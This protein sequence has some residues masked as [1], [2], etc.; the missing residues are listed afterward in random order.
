MIQIFGVASEDRIFGEGSNNQF[1]G[2]RRRAVFTIGISKKRL[3]APIKRVGFMG[4]DNDQPMQIEIQPSAEYK[5]GL[6]DLGFELHVSIMGERFHRLKGSFFVETTNNIYYWLKNKGEMDFEFDG[7][8]RLVLTD[9]GGVY[10][11]PS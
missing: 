1:T 11:L 2:R 6:W 3:D 10:R 9:Y 7:Y 4:M 5:N 8:S